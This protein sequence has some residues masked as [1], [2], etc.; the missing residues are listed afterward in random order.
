[1]LDYFEAQRPQQGLT[2]EAY[3][4][5]WQERLQQP[6]TGL[7]RTAR[8]YHFYRTYNWDRSAR[9]QAAY[10]LSEALQARLHHL[11]PQWW[12]VLTEDWCVDSAFALP[13]VAAAAQAAPDV[14]LRILER[15]ANLDLM[16]RYLT[17]GSRS[18][19]VVVAISHDGEERFTW[20]PRP[21]AAQALREAKLAEGVDGA[22]VAKLVIDYYETG[23]WGDVDTELTQLIGRTD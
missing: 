9:V 14:K 22:Q 17:N 16:D 21:R 18:I 15:E 7:D 23:G 8:R 13:V 20:G 11:E 6:T 4:T 2:Y 1:M 19:P 5:L 12:M 10:T 3:L